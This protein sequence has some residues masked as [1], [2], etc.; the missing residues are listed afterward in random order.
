MELEKFGEDLQW[1]DLEPGDTGFP[2]LIPQYY[3]FSFYKKLDRM[4]SEK[5]DQY[6]TQLEKRA[7]QKLR[8]LAR[9]G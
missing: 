1:E 8:D 7:K 4:V 5:V 2:R 3:G 9:R 6:T